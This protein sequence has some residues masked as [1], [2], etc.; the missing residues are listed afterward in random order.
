MT[1]ALITHSDCLNHVTPPGHPE[2]VDRLKTLFELF[3]SAEF[4]GLQ[5]H[6]A[7][8]CG[9][10][11]IERAHPRQYYDRIAAAGP[12]RGFTSLDPDTHMS[13]GSLNAARRAA[14]ANVLAVDLVL[15]GQA[16]N[17]FCAVRPPG[18]HAEETRAMGFC[19]FSNV[20]IGALH[21]LDE[22]GL[23]RVAIVDFDVHH[24]NGSSALAWDDE[25]IFL[26][27]QP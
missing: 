13:P 8:L 17:A 14:G 19:L 10:S 15:G 24:G 12:Q 6:E 5:R 22:H 21:A 23:E 16:D 27:L 26:C 18:H 3:K 7:P 1:T 4:D 2:R 9:I 20:I 11:S 25:R